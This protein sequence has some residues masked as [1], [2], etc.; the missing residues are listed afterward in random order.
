M[1]KKKVKPDA[2]ITFLGVLSSCRHAGLEQG[3]LYF[4][5][6]VEYGLEAEVDHYSCIVDLLGRAGDFENARERR[7]ELEPECAATHLQ[8]VNLYAS[9]GCW[10]QVARVQ[11]MMKDKGLI[12]D[13]GHSWIEIRNEVYRFRA[14]GR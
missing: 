7:L 9:S 11:K 2:I 13:P 1:R 3:Q 8:L 5:S 12:T 4:N 6:M 14:S 10:D